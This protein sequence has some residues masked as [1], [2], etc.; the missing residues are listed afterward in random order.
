MNRLRKSRERHRSTKSPPQWDLLHAQ[1]EDDKI[2]LPNSETIYITKTKS[3]KPAFGRKKSDRLLQDFGFDILGQSFGIPSL[4]DTERPRRMSTASQ[5]SGVISA[6]GATQPHTAPAGSRKV[7]HV[8]DLDDFPTVV[9]KN[10]ARSS[11]DVPRTVHHRK[12]KS[13]NDSYYRNTT[14]AGNLYSMAGTFNPP[15]PPPPPPAHL[16]NVQS[17]TNHMPPMP[18]MPTNYT[19]ATYQPGSS[20]YYTAELPSTGTIPYW[21]LPPSNIASGPR[22]LDSSGLTA[23]RTASM[24]FVPHQQHL[25][26]SFSYP[27]TASFANTTHAPIS[28]PLPPPPPPPLSQ[29]PSEPRFKHER[30][31]KARENAPVWNRRE[32]KKLEAHYKSVAKALANKQEKHKAQEEAED[33]KAEGEKETRQHVGNSIRHTH[34][35]AGCGKKRSRKYRKAHPLKKGQIP[36]PDYCYKCIQDAVF[37]D[38]NQSNG[39]SADEGSVMSYASEPPASSHSTDEGRAISSGQY[40]R[41]KTRHGNR[42]MRRSGHL[43]FLANMLY[44]SFVPRSRT[45]SSGSLSSAEEASSRASSP[46]AGPKVHR[47]PKYPI[48]P[49]R[50]SS[51][52]KGANDSK[53]NTPENHP[54]PTA[55][56]NR[57]RS[58]ETVPWPVASASYAPANYH[59]DEGAGVPS[60]PVA[61]QEYSQ[62]SRPT[63]S[64][65]STK[66]PRDSPFQYRPETAE[67]PTGSHGPHVKKDSS[68]KP[69][70]KQPSFHNESSETFAA[71]NYSEAGRNDAYRTFNSHFKFDQPTS[72]FDNTRE[73]GSADEHTHEQATLP[74]RDWQHTP[75]WEVTPDDWDQSDK[76]EMPRT[77]VDT[78]YFDETALPHIVDG[79]WG[80]SRSD[81]ER[82]AEEQ[83]E[84]D[85]AAAGKLFSDLGSSLRGS[86]TSPFPTSSSLTRST[87]SVES[88][89]S[90]DEQIGNNLDYELASSSDGEQTAK[91]ES[92]SARKLE[93]SSCEDKRQKTTPRITNR[94]RSTSSSRT[95]KLQPE[96][97]ALCAKNLYSLDEKDSNYSSDMFNSP[98]DSSVFGHTGHSKDDLAISPY[99]FVGSTVTDT[100]GRVRRFMRL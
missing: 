34:V 14:E 92:M 32:A 67:V 88:C 51:D 24:Q 64:G 36:E 18:P 100:R 12:S 11:T 4:Q 93:F 10:S 80:R 45:I 61:S 59:H 29:W 66:I 7:H 20:Q 94:S 23:P 46:I 19:S 49:L 52:E 60:Q 95:V 83:A 17:V 54:D 50:P 82:E 47:K 25:P 78:R 38:A 87:I 55:N 70:Y 97:S 31:P 91:E 15:P 27:E 37:S 39:D 68:L 73:H 43:S 2:Y 42:W 77:P 3:G 41:K 53:T 86:G 76:W 40:V 90:D 35:C 89:S 21:R 69:N 28:A 62:A 33:S 72:Q 81:I 98:S 65:A 71:F 85:L 5:T 13:G 57:K 16:W 44:G 8:Y 48:P 84:R 74:R 63:K 22:Y 99:G 26:T 30:V 9:E 79:G 56:A 1:D 58:E 75:F 96:S 6:S